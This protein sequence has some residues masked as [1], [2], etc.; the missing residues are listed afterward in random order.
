MGTVP[1]HTE[2][3]QVEESRQEVLKKA[4]LDRAIP[5]GKLAERWSPEPPVIIPGLLPGD[6]RLMQVSGPSK[7]GKSLVTQELVTTLG[8]GWPFLGLIGP[9]HERKDSDG[10]WHT[11]DGLEKPERTLYVQ[12]ENSEF[13]MEKRARNI[14]KREVASDVWERYLFERPDWRDVEAPPAFRAADNVDVVV[15]ES[16]DLFDEDQVAALEEVLIERQYRNLVLDSI[17]LTVGGSLND[18]VVAKRLVRLLKGLNK[19]TGTRMICI[20]HASTKG[21]GNRRAKESMGSTFFTSA[22]W[23]LT[24]RIDR[25]G[26]EYTITPIAR[27]HDFEPFVAI[28]KDLAQWESGAASDRATRLRAW[29]EENDLEIGPK[30]GGVGIQGWTVKAIASALGWSTGSVSA[31]MNEVFLENV[32]GSLKM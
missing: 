4:F 14:L 30:G 22:A 3:V 27:D 1:E 17:Y 13:S 31:A 28:M 20:H 26:Q 15:L 10:R 18:E 21:D 16:M 6:V 9:Q 29:L 7:N 2:E 12:L 11:V 24:W 19:R 8:T 25:E 32:G 23:D 5:M